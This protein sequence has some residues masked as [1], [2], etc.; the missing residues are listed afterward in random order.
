MSKAA[1]LEMTGLSDVGRVREHNEDA[2]RWDATAG[3]AILADGMGGHLAGE[4]ASEMAIEVIAAHLSSPGSANAPLPGEVLQAAVSEA[5]GAIHR[6]AQADLHCHNMGT[7][8]VAVA[9]REGQLYCAHVGDSRLYRFNHE[10]LAL[11]TH[12]HSLVQ[13]LVDEGMMSSEEAADS[14]HKNVIT[15]ALGLE[16][17]VEVDLMQLPLATGDLFLLCSDGLSDPLGEGELARLLGDGELSSM[18]QALVD[19]ANAR[20]GD[21]NVSLILMRMG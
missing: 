13:E 10:G 1:V 6:R 21:D 4:V 3:W 18:A 20:G 7:T 5:N 17:S 9:V 8:V 19:A 2:I 12:D 15:R 16:A 11:L 14:V